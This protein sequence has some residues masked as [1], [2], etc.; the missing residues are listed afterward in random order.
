MALVARIA[1]VTIAARVADAVAD[2]ARIAVAPRATVAAV[3]ERIAVA[4]DDSVM[5]YNII[6]SILCDSGR[7]RSRIIH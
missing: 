7:S 1:A 4:D 6:S 2:V 5:D 3:T